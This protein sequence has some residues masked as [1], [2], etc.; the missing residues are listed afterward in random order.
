MEFDEMLISTGV[1]ALIKLVRDKG[2]IEMTMASRLLNIPLSTIEEWSHALESEGI[3]KIEYQ[4]TKV[5]LAWVTTHTGAIDEKLSKI[6]ESE[7]TLKGEVDALKSKSREQISEV[8]EF[9]K[10]F[11]DNYSK[12]IASMD[13]LEEKNN[14]FKKATGFNTEDFYKALDSVEASKRK[15]DES[16]ATIRSVKEQLEKTRRELLG[17][18]NAK[19]VEELL[20]H[21][22]TVE[23]L[24]GELDKV[25]EEI[26]SATE[27]LNSRQVDIPHLNKYVKSLESDISALQ[28]RM[29]EASEGVEK[30]KGI[31]SEIDAKSAELD[32]EGMS[33][34]VAMEGIA[35]AEDEF[36][37]LMK[38]YEAG[39]KKHEE[40]VKR[41]EK[42]GLEASE[43]L[44]KLNSMHK[45]AAETKKLH[46]EFAA[47]EKRISEVFENQADGAG[48]GT[49]RKSIETIST[50][51]AELQSKVKAGMDR[52]QEMEGA[53]AGID[54]I[55]KEMHEVSAMSELAAR[56]AARLTSEY[57]KAHAKAE[58]SGELLDKANEG[59]LK[60]KKDMEAL[61]KHA[62]EV[63]GECGIS[64]LDSLLSESNALGERIAKFESV[65]KE[66]LPMFENVDGLL[67]SITALKKKVDAERTRL[68]EESGAIFSSLDA[69]M[70]TYA[71][72]QKIKANAEEAIEGYMREIEKAEISYETAVSSADRAHQ[73]IE[74]I[75]GKL[76]GKEDM[77]RAEEISRMLEK[78]SEEKARLDG[79]RARIESLDAIAERCSRQATLISKE[80]DLLNLRG[81]IAGTGSRGGA[82]VGAP[83]G[84]APAKSGGEITEEI[85]LTNAEQDEFEKKRDEL[86]KLV[87]DM[88]ENNGGT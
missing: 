41:S 75:I 82:H 44:E 36:G 18:D 34:E 73:R 55:K 3:L 87:K 12:L 10:E 42:A 11:N 79:I 59:A 7:A 37:T 33:L 67:S 17:A 57:E 8:V 9:K 21:R 64:E 15:M 88:W 49:I 31:S 22:G 71:T 68:A 48:L 25:S 69:E 28:K 20:A 86:K 39:S 23:S 13:A 72:F 27:A 50:E 60:L 61:R 45:S 47:L 54:E 66:A 84:G 38:E 58:K 40:L 2:K 14:E 6:E 16:S 1:D 62:A 63:R 30:L 85:K 4:L 83:S 46:D 80:I 5:Y 76:Q 19:K 51:L 32:K 81:G 35:A 77:Q 43:L 56:N 78:F 52:V 74:G 29:N 26:K 24:K 70:E 53:K 65:A